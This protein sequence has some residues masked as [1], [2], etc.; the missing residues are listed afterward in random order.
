MKRRVRNITWG[1]LLLAV[2]VLLI[3]S[4]LG[5]SLLPEGLGVFRI[6]VLACCASGVISG[7]I[8]LEMWSLAFGVGIGYCVLAEPLGWPEIS[9]WIMILAIAIAGAGLS[10]IFHRKKHVHVYVDGK[11]RDCVFSN[12]EAGRYS[13]DYLQGDIVFSSSTKYIESQNF[14]GGN[15][16]CV[17]SHYALYF[18][19]ASLANG[20]ATLNFDCVFSSC[21]IYIPSNWNIVD[22]TSHVFSSPIGGNSMNSNQPTLTLNGDCVFGKINIHRV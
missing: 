16:D 4:Q 15:F 17:F 8:N 6:I 7:I 2:A 12:D 18:D 21:D 20:E 1:L 14:K 22:N 11:E 9:V 5:Y 3:A 10:M 13:E 19:N